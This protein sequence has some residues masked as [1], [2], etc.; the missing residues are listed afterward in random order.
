M[1]LCFKSK[2]IISQFRSID[3]LNAVVNGHVCSTFLSV[4]RELRSVAGVAP[5]SSRLT[6]APF[7]RIACEGHTI[8]DWWLARRQR[9]V[10]TTLLCMLDLCVQGH[11]RL[12][13]S[14]LN[15]FCAFVRALLT[16]SY[17]LEAREETPSKRRRCWG[18]KRT[19]KCRGVRACTDVRS[20]V[21]RRRSV[22]QPRNRATHATLGLARGIVNG[23]TALGSTGM[24][25]LDGSSNRYRVH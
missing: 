10:S 18:A 16:C 4:F 8:G 14:N 21:L 9:T 1:Y 24:R 22:W 5:P 23:Q 25:G 3:S 15:G 17:T 20:G 6:A 19:P 12:F 11:L 13:V 7:S 2:E